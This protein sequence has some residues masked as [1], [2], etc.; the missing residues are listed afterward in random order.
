MAAA[1]RVGDVSNHGG[2]VVGPGVSTVLIGGMPAAVMGDNHVCVIPPPTH[3]PSSPFVVGSTTVLIG[4]MP[5]LRTTDVCGCGAM[6][7]VGC[8]TVLIG[9]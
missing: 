7:M 3:I 9:G 6:P 8:L 2:T 1:A 5:A 4:G